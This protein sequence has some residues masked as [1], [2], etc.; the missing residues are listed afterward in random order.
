MNL[1]CVN[2]PLQCD[3]SQVETGASW[4]GGLVAELL[5]RQQRHQEGSRRV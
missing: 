2:T 5:T 4:S 3:N 1:Q